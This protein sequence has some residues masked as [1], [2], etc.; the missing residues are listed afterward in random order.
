MIVLV[1]MGRSSQRLFYSE[2][3]KVGKKMVVVWAGTSSSGLSGIK[4]GRPIRFTP[5]DLRAIKDHCPD[6]ELVTPQVRARFREA[7]YRNRNA[8]GACASAGRIFG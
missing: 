4:G 8:Q 7:K 1:G 5:D 3:R 6:V 2:F